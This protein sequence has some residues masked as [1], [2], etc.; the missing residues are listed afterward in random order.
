MREMG[1]EL[2]LFSPYELDPATGKPVEAKPAEA[3]PLE[4]AAG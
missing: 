4:T 2:E 1:Q 3:A